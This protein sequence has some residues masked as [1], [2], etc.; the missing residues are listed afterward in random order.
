MG[1]AILDSGLQVNF[2]GSPWA[3]RYSSRSVLLPCRSPRVEPSCDP[4]MADRLSRVQFRHSDMDLAKLRLLSRYSS[5]YG[6]GGQKRLRTFRLPG[7]A[8]PN[9]S[10][11]QLAKGSAL[12]IPLGN[13][14]QESGD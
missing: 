11:A 1:A 10:A 6:P 7:Q 5:R 13:G 2:V 14:S 4:F 3:T 12:D 9:F 8:H